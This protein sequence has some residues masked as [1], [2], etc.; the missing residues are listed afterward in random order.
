MGNNVIE[1]D[2]VC[3]MGDAGEENKDAEWDPK[4]LKK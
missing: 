2:G 4:F 3:E 1:E